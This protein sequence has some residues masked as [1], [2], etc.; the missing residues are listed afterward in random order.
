ME[1]GSRAAYYSSG[2]VYMREALI[3]GLLFACSLT[4]ANSPPPVTFS[5]DV[6]PVLQKSCQGCHRPGEAVPF[7][8]LTYEESRPWAKAMKEAVLLR[9]MP[10]WFADPQIGEFSNDRSL[11]QKDIATLAAWSDQGAPQGDPK[12]APAPLQFLEGWRIPKP[13]VV[14][15]MPIDFKVPA[16]G[17]LG[18]QHIVVPSGFTEDRWVQCAEVRPGNPALVHHIVVFTREPGSKW[19]N[20][21]KPGVPFDPN[22]KKHRRKKDDGVPGEGVAGYTP[23]AFPMQLP[24]GQAILIKAGSDIVFQ[25]HY[26]TN[27]KP[28]TDR[29]RLGLVF[30]PGPPKQRVSSLAAYNDDLKIP[31]GDPNYR[32]DSVFDLGAEVQ[33]TS[34]QPHMHY[35]GKDFEFRAI[36]PNGETETLLRVINYKFNWQLSYDLA[37]P[38]VL[39]KGTRIQCTAHFDN[40][41][42]NPSNPDPTM[43]VIWGDQSSDEMMIGFFGVAFD[44]N[45]PLKSLTAEPAKEAKARPKSQKEMEAL[46][47][48][49]DARTP[50][51]QL[52]A[53]ENVITN[54]ADTEFKVMLLQTAMQIEQRKDDFA[55]L[56][57]YGERLI[58]A[59]PKGAFALVT[60]ASETAR[61]THMFDL[62]KEEKLARV[63]K[64]AQAGLE[65]AKFMPKPAG[66]RD[67][68]WE[69]AK[70]DF[71]AQA[72]EAM[73]QAAMLRQRYDEA[74]IDYNQA[75][76]V[77]A[78]PNAVTWTRLGQAYQNLGRLDDAFDA[79]DKAV[80]TPNVTPEVKSVAQAKKDEVAKRRGAGSK[81]SSAQ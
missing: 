32:V 45:L 54:F 79:F 4:A 78:T 55:Q 73:G 60:I 38:I 65:A 13:D 71:Q 26:T 40:S 81:P 12:D 52:Q 77:A 31:A 16:S 43:E 9:K 57:F 62:D 7:S 61:H 49:Q 21:A 80:A 67:D 22:S 48:F 25:M 3:S 70:K 35:R 76:K 27:G 28:G 41:A 37:K 2:H 29:S 47:A 39:P 14:I 56:L 69:G 19:L 34:M 53:I 24:P 63:D 64:Y 36:Y 15:E 30:A 59:D 66:V 1:S 20:D 23:G 68:Q 74:V 6:L 33:L 11:S 58:N 42:N 51:Q 50:D 46:R 10:P 72:Y 17:I 75:I 8:L 44:A 18:L 5:K